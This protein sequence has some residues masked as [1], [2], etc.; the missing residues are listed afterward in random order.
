[1]FRGELLNFQGVRWVRYIQYNIQSV[2]A[3]CLNIICSPL[4]TNLKWTCINKQM[5]L[6]VFVLEANMKKV[7]NDKQK[8]GGD[9]KPMMHQLRRWCNGFLHLPGSDPDMS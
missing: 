1:M 2:E 4:P 5:I 8:L 3:F 7:T 9:K 6:C